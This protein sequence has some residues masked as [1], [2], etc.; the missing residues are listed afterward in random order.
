[1]EVQNRII[2]GGGFQQGKTLA[3]ATK[4]FM[5]AERERQLLAQPAIRPR[6]PA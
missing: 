2:V 3:P 1:M 4:P 5:S 6:D